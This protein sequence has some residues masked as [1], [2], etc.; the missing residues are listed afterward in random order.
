ME[1]KR[2]EAEIILKS[3]EKEVLLQIVPENSTR[4]L[5]LLRGLGPTTVNLN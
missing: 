1:F 5:L 2:M 3:E 4:S